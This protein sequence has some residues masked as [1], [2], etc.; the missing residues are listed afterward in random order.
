[1]RARHET[2]KGAWIFGV[3]FFDEPLA[4]PMAWVLVPTR[5]SAVPGID[6]STATPMLDRYQRVNIF[7]TVQVGD[8]SWFLVGPGQWVEER[9]LARVIPVTRPDGVKGRWVAVNLYE[10][11]A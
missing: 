8:W 6:P 9:R 11:V 5:P 2:N 4:Y 7:A 1:M 10:Q 3:V